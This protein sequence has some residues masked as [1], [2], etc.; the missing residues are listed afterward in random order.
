MICPVC[1]AD[2]PASGRRQYCSDA[3]KQHAWRARHTVAP[4]AARVAPIDSVYQC[5]ACE[6]RYLGVRRCPDCNL[7]N[8]R[9]GP[10]GPCP[11]CDEI[12][13]LSDIVTAPHPDPNQTR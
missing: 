6:Q 12:V 2:F 3:C 4:I 11:H 9:L 1:G 5:A 8:R 7:F 10:G 13:A